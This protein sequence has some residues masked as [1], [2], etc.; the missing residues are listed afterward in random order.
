MLVGNHLLSRDFVRSYRVIFMRVVIT[1]TIVLLLR[2]FGPY[3]ITS[4]TVFITLDFPVII[5]GQ[6]TRN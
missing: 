3:G 2:D 4:V 5:D 1:V 6:C